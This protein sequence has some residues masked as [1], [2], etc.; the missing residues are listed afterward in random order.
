MTGQRDS[1][2]LRPSGQGPSVDAFAGTRARTGRHLTGDQPSTVLFG[3]DAMSCLG[4][5]QLVD[6]RMGPSRRPAHSDVT[7]VGEPGLS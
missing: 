5:G 7:S 6:G 2:R 3:R 4:A 1:G